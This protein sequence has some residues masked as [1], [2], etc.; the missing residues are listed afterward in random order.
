MA[1]ALNNLLINWYAIKQ[2]TETKPKFI[3]IYMNNWREFAW[4]LLYR[5]QNGSIPWSIQDVSE[6]SISFH[7]LI[8]RPFLV[9]MITNFKGAL[10]YTHCISAGGKT[11]FL[12]ELPGY[13]IKPSD[14]EALALEISGMLN[15]SSL[16]F[17]PVPLWPGGVAQDRILSMCQ[18][19][20][21]VYKQMS[22]VKLWLLH[23]KFW[24]HF[25]VNLCKKSSRSFKNVINKIC[26]QNHIYT[27]HN[28]YA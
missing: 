24:T 5:R 22:D 12:N 10:E 6:K 8:T 11:P 20:Q 19:E 4:N 18:T 2:R 28:I 26:L 7:D 1:L 23:R 16:P 15:T 3:I 9:Q 21:T 27:V 17:F 25:R 14:G 13:E